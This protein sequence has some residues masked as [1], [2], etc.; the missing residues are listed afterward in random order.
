MT[1][2]TAIIMIHETH[3]VNCK[4]IKLFMPKKDINK[5]SVEP[6]TFILFSLNLESSK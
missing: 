4:K 1:L 6:N 5:D 2:D 3:D